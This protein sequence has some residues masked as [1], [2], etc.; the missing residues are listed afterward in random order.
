M[1]KL[2]MKKL[3]RRRRIYKVRL[4]ASLS[5]TRINVS[6]VWGIMQAGASGVEFTKI[7]ADLFVLWSPEAG[8]AGLSEMNR[9]A[10]CC[11]FTT[12]RTSIM[13]IHPITVN[14]SSIYIVR[15]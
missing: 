1:K 15:Y 6:G 12:T 4:V 5:Y 2:A 11:M 7:P 13:H 14:S 9:F 8:L 10:R 3:R